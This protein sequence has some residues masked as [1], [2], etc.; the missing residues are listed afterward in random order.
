MNHFAQIWTAFTSLM[1]K[2]TGRIIVNR[3]TIY[4]KEK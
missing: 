3:K 1:P 2:L 4:E